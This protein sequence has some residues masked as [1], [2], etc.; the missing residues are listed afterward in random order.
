MASVRSGIDLYRY[1]LLLGIAVQ[2][3]TLGLLV[4]DPAV[5]RLASASSGSLSFSTSA[6]GSTAAGQ[7]YAALLALL[8]I[9]E[10]VIAL[11]AFVRWRRGVVELRRTYVPYGSFDPLPLRGPAQRA[12]GGYRR[13]LWT[14][15]TI[16]LVTIAGTVVIAIL[17]V[18][19]FALTTNANGTV[20][21]PTSQQIDHAVAA[22]LPAIVALALAVFVLELVLAYF[23]ADSLAGF[24]ELGGAR[25]GSVDLDATRTLVIVS[26]VL[27]VSGLLNLV[28]VGAGALAIASPVLLLYACQRYLRAFD[29]VMPGTGF[30][31]GPTVPGPVP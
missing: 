18:S 1:A 24:V 26:V 21:P 10:L 7:G 22:T 19:S 9:A 25:P 16:V 4:A 14:M 31:P 17:L 30:R 20:Q 3:L 5:G 28:A 8:G 12:E 15:L 6:T 2:L 29:E 23:V 11:V 27:S 13:A